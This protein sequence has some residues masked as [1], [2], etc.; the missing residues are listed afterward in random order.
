MELS[1]SR[2]L[3]ALTDPTRRAI[4]QMLNERDMT[5]GEIGARFAI[6][7]PSISHHLSVLKHAELVR[8]ERSGQT[9]IYS[10]NSTVVQEFLQ[11][12]MQFFNVG[13]TNHA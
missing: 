6:S 10:L 12:L 11:Q 3:Q 4:L 1:L 5:A 2:T 7:A 13:E 9:I 8:A